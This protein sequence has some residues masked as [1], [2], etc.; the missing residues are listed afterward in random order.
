M[1]PTVLVLLVVALCFGLL[2]LLAG[3]RGRR[4]N[5]HPVCACCKFDLEGSYPESVTC[6]ECGA[7]LKRDRGVLTGVRRRMPLLAATGALLI[8]TSLLPFG[9]V[10]YSAVTGSDINTL[11]PLGFI[12]WES[13]FADQARG[14]KLADEIMS[15]ILSNKLDPAQ[16]QKVIGAVLDMQA[17]PNRAWSENWGELIERARFDGVLSK[18]DEARFAAQAPVFEL[19]VRPKASAGGL[20]PV[21]VRLK[22]ARVGATSSMYCPV[23]ID[24]VRIGGREIKPTPPA[25]PTSGDLGNLRF[26]NG[27]MGAN[28]SIFSL[29]GSGARGMVRFGGMSG[30]EQLG[31]VYELPAD[32]ATGTQPVE[33][34]ISAS[35]GEQRTLNSFSMV[36]INGQIQR[37]SQ[38]QSDT[39]KVPVALSSKV[40]VVGADQPPVNP[41]EPSAE[42][43][44]KLE[45]SLRPR[46][47]ERAGGFGGGMVP[48]TL[49]GNP[50]SL[51]FDCA[52]LPG[53]VAY[54]VIVRN[55][56]GEAKLGSFTS[57][58]PVNAV[59]DPF[60]FA[61]RSLTISINGRTQVSNSG[62]SG[63]QVRE[64]SG[65]LPFAPGDSVDV[66]LK[67]APG[68]AAAT[69]DQTT[70]IDKVLEFKGVPVDPDPFEELDRRMQGVFQRNGI[71]PSRRVPR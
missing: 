12:L 70:Y 43:L 59:E 6:P 1:L 50:V 51:R 16:Y 8:L 35:P 53:E 45:S 4:I 57:G 41:V 14:Q 3:W 9:V 32:L 25:A 19:E 23:A 31:A 26:F 39:P 46:S 55:A 66:I 24:S 33:V 47:L 29:N 7:G 40:E 30:R 44:A 63:G 60:A 52:S 17:D 11:K 54:D 37:N 69:L 28:N 27:G 21:V 49:G 22:E 20:I 62:P 68:A 34:A 18:Q 65:Y 5:D 56:K 13:R 38:P 15:R 10:A 64:V 42:Q 61:T 67:P 71:G 58:K 2:L 36:I 48:G